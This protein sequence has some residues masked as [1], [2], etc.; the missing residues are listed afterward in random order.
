MLPA[1]HATAVSQD[2]GGDKDLFEDVGEVR[3]VEAH[4]ALAGGQ[5]L[6]VARRFVPQRRDEDAERLHLRVSPSD[7]WEDRGSSSDRILYSDGPQ[8]R[9]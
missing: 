6:D 9:T 4:E 2:V 5:L 3:R 1:A 8:Y 7:D